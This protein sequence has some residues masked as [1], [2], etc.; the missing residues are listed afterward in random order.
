M[1]KDNTVPFNPE[2]AEAVMRRRVHRL[3]PIARRAFATLISSNKLSGEDI[4]MVI[5]LMAGSLAQQSSDPAACLDTM[6][7][8]AALFAE[9]FNQS[10]EAS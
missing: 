7:R 2:S 3:M 10:D 5:A 8:Q 9:L 1:S 6:G 4:G